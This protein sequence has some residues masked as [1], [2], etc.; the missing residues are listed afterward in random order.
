MAP[1]ADDDSKRY[2]PK[3]QNI[4]Q[5]ISKLTLI[6]VAD[7]NELLKVSMASNL[8]FKECSFAID[9]STV[10]I[11]S[12]FIL[13]ENSKDRRCTNGDSGCSGCS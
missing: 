9:E 1:Q 7:L 2:S 11:I 4:V 12:N 13:V 3:I 10:F 8:L 6:E 5:E